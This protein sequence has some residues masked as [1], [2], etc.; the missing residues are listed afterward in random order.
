MT[1]AVPLGGVSPCTRRVMNL[2]NFLSQAARRHS[3]EIGFVWGE[4]D[5]ELGRNGGARQR[6]GRRPCPATTASSRATAFWSSRPTA[7]RCS[8]RCLPAS[9]WGPSG[10]R[11]I[12]VNRPAEVAFLAEAS[13]ARGMISGAAFPDH[14]SACLEAAPGA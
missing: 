6:H 11:P 13:G 10:F 1:E 4:D 9:G 12:T 7:T 2:A 3:E 8:N 5:L 14:V